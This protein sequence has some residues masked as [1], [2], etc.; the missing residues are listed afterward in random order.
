MSEKIPKSPRIASMFAK[1]AEQGRGA[2]VLYVTAGDP[3]FG[4]SV[5]V[6][7]ITAQA[8]ADMLELGVPFSDP[9]ADGEANQ[10]AAERAINSGINQ[11]KVLEIAAETRKRHPSLPIVLFTY[12]NPILF[13]NRL[14]FID[15]CLKANES[16]V[17]AILPLDLPSDEKSAKKI[18]DEISDCGLGLASI[19]TPKTSDSRIAQ[20][21]SRA[22]SFIYYVSREGVTGE[23]KTFSA[24]FA[25]RISAIRRHSPL[26]VVAGFGISN[27]DHVKA[28]LGTGVDGVVVGSALVRKV[29]A[30]SKGLCSIDE[31]GAFVREIC[32]AVRDA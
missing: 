10:L 9:L 19:V 12:L 22:S 7:D 13:S 18:A 32:S 2:A 15:F 11:L 29:E 5:Q 8:G 25:D 27:A 23:S 21:A 1:C 24:N 16:G 6:C 31:I 28:A 17:C 20:L 3:D 14:S 26:P 4:R 30:Y